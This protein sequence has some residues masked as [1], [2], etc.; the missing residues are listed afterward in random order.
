MRRTRYRVIQEHHVSYEPEETAL[1]FKSEH[2]II[3]R[4]NRLA[5]SKPSKYFKQFLVN[6]AYQHS[7]SY[8]QI[9]MEWLQAENMEKRRLSRL[10]KRR[11][12]S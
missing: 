3:T 11:R 4:L 9:E 10:K 2:H 5:K 6:W 8:F 12:K 1:V 7:D